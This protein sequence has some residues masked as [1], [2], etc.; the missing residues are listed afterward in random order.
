M[1]KPTVIAIDL[2]KTVFQVSVTK[3][4]QVIS[5]KQMRRK[6]LEQFLARS[7]P[8]LVA[9]EAC[10][11]AHHWGRLAQRCGHDVVL[12][13]AGRVKTFLVGQKTDA[14]D[15][16][17]IGEAAV[18]P[19]TRT[20]AVKS[21]EMSALQAC[22]RLH[23]HLTDQSTA[24]S[25]LIRGTFAEF[26]VTIAKGVNRFQAAVPELLEDP[27]VPLPINARMALV[28]AFDYWCSQRK[29]LADIVA[30]LH[31]LCKAIEPCKRLI[32]LEGVAHMNAIGLY[33]AIGDGRHFGKGRDAA[34]CVGVTPKQNSS[35][36]Q[37]TMRGIGRRSG[38]KRLRS[39]LITGCWSM[40]IALKQR[41]PRTRTEHWLANKIASRG[42]G[43]AAVALA[44]RQVRVAWALLHNNTQYD[45]AYAA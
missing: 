9:M 14:N 42:P 44:N 38:N 5:N 18:H 23:E 22:K 35:G 6:P 16:L 12:V 45:P 17:A 3:H 15:A 25:N 21:E 36:G 19:N 26:G 11:S 33:L 30:R 2:A 4:S 34:A 20:V 31:Q 7:K 28:T 1:T 39:S 29:S 27:E 43:R 32:A 24:T 10:S 8:A 13:P 40:V 37:V 41:A